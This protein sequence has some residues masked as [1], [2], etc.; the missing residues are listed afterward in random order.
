MTRGGL[1]LL[2]EGVVMLISLNH[3]VKII[4]AEIENCYNE[5]QEQI[6]K[7]RKPNERRTESSVLAVKFHSDHKEKKKKKLVTSQQT[8]RDV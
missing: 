3:I 2:S 7:K 1:V 8:V 5:K 6:E 4:Y